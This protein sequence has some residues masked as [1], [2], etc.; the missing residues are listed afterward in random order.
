MTNTVEI[1]RNVVNLFPTPI[2]ISTTGIILTKKEL[3][4]VKKIKEDC[5]LSTGNIRS[6]DSYILEK[7]EFIHIKKELEKEIKYYFKEVLKAA[8]VEPYI[9][10]SWL[11]YTQVNQFHH[12]HSH[13]NSLVSGVFYIEADKE[14][15]KISFVKPNYCQQLELK[16]KEFNDWN[17]KSWA[18]PTETGDVFLFPSTLEHNV[19]YKKGTN[20]RISLAFNIF[21]KGVLGQE[22]SLTFLKV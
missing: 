22:N 9:T 3:D 20:T 18:L 10:Q 13:P 2:Y 11:N 21:V 19:D 14:N 17:S 8:D 4:F 15:D 5:F 6:K 16:V 7:K 1:K 12:P